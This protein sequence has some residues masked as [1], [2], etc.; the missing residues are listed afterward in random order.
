MANT[1]YNW[2]SVFGSNQQMKETEMLFTAFQKADQDRDTNLIPQPFTNQLNLW[3]FDINIS[4]KEF[5]TLVTF[6][7]KWDPNYKDML[8]IA[9]H[10]EVMIMH[11][12][13]VRD[14]SLY[15]KY[16][17]NPGK[18]AEVALLNDSDLNRIR[19]D[20]DA[21]EYYLEDVRSNSYADVADALLY[22]KIRN[23]ELEIP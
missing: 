12:F 3:M 10:L 23:N 16:L 22:E 4:V 17:Y 6:D 5:F 18:A 1:C 19:Y 21:D 13:E 11:D 8:K 15:G 7:T 2:I 14:S 9:D 20:E